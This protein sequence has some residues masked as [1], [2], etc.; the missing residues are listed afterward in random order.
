MGCGT[1]SPDH[2]S[3]KSEL[4]TENAIIEFK[5]AMDTEQMAAWPAKMNTELAMLNSMDAKTA[6][7]KKKEKDEAIAAQKNLVNNKKKIQAD[8]SIA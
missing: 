1:S 2:E 7:D 4:M 8:K 3:N 5:N 6:A